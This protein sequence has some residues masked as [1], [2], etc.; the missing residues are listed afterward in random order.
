MSETIPMRYEGGGMFRCLR[1]GR[2]AVQ[3]GRVYPMQMAENRSK[4]SHDHFFA[5]VT[6]AWKNLPESLSGE[7]SSPDHL[8]KWA[9]IKAGFCSRADIVCANN[10]EALRLA[11][12]VSRIDRF[13]LVELSGKTVTIWTADSQRRD[14]MG[15]KLFQQAKERALHVISELIGT[16]V[17]TLKKNANASE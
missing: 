5:C 6:E 4:A 13:S 15:R 16:D 14:E 3:A 11:A 9:L 2:L 10:E 12:T 8:R 7:F 17:A 1:P